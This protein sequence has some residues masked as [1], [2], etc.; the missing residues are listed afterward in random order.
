MALSLI[1]TTR[2]PGQG[3]MQL[4][5]GCHGLSTGVESGQ[6]A[7]YYPG[8]GYYEL[9]R[10][11]TTWP[12]ASACSPILGRTLNSARVVRQ[13]AIN[14]LVG[15]SPGH[16][17]GTG[18]ADKLRAPHS[19]PL[20]LTVRHGHFLKIRQGDGVIFLKSTGDAGLLEI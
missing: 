13:A 18:V 20:K 15:P 8:L 3:G 14:S 12:I 4:S 9:R 16:D 7:L 11:K 5:T 2:A 17:V 10:G 19:R 6:C 1:D